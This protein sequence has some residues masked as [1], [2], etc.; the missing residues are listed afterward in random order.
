[1]ASVLD[2]AKHGHD[3]SYDRRDSVVDSQTMVAASV[4]ESTTIQPV[5][6]KRVNIYG[7]FEFQTW[8]PPASFTDCSKKTSGQRPT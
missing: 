3:R 4:C 5:L 7:L 8:Y 2:T 6:L 1:M